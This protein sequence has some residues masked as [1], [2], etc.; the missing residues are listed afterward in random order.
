MDVSPTPAIVAEPCQC[1]E[2]TNEA[3]AKH[4]TQLDVNWQQI[5]GTL[6]TTIALSTSVVEKR[7]GARPVRMLPNYCPI[8]GQRYQKESAS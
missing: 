3:L 2:K 7:R 4:N 5:D 6:V 8:C 1:I